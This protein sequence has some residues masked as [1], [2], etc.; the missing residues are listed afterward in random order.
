MIK[1]QED[2]IKELKDLM[3]K[4]VK[5]I[6]EIVSMS[7][8]GNQQRSPEEKNMINSQLKSLNEILK[9]T[10]DEITATLED[11]AVIKPLP[12]LKINNLQADVKRP[13]VKSPPAEKP[14]ASHPAQIIKKSNL[15]NEISDLERSIL[16]RLKKGEKKE[17]EKKDPKPSSYIR[18]ANRLFGEKSKKWVESKFFVS[19]KRD[20]IKANMKYVPA[21][22]VA[23]TAFTT[24]ASI[25]VGLFIFLFFMFFSLGFDFPFIHMAEGGIGIRLLHTFWILFAV[26]VITFISMYAYPSLEKS[27]LEGKINQELPFATIHMSAIS[28]SLVEPSKIFRILIETKEYP[29]L[30]R[31]FTKLIN[32]INV[33]GYDFVTA[34]RN[35]GFNSASTKL[36]ELFNGIATTVNSGGDLQGFFDKRAQ[37]LLFDYRIE[38]EKYAKTAET[39]MDIYISLVIAAP[40]ILMLLLIMMRVSGLGISLSTS[41]ITLIMVLGVTTINIL[42]LTFLQLKS[43]TS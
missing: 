19:L 17:K 14:R 11:M 43:P 20:I 18:T 33:Y 38:R 41:A 29:F 39:F 35:V 12:S 9:R 27:Y 40:M 23:L 2:Y 4:E 16:K 5:I 32:E 34:L 1:E 37:T 13:I 42:F 30:G 36:S 3:R 8:G 26:P 7:K 15:K 22:Y 10:A 31:E 25:F 24:F 6:R 28:G 21:S